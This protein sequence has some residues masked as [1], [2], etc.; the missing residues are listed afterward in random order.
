MDGVPPQGRTD[1]GNR[2]SAAINDVPEPSGNWPVPALLF[3]SSRRSSASTS[4]RHS[5]PLVS[6]RIENG[7][8]FGLDSTDNVL[9][10]FAFPEWDSVW[11]GHSHP[12]LPSWYFVLDDSQSPGSVKVVVLLVDRNHHS[13]VAGLDGNG[14]KRWEVPLSVQLSWNG[15]SLPS[16]FGP[17]LA[18][19]VQ[20]SGE[21]RFFTVAVNEPR[22]PSRL[23][24]LDPQ[25]GE[26]T[27]EYCHPG[28]FKSYSAHDFDND[29][30][31]E[32]VFGG[33][34]NPGSG[35]GHPCVVMFDLPGTNEPS[36]SRDFFGRPAI[37][38]K[39]YLLLPRSRLADA[40]RYMAIVYNLRLTN[41]SEIVAGVISG[42]PD[43]S[44]SDFY[45]LKPDFSLLRLLIGD[46]HLTLFQRLQTSAE[47]VSP[48]SFASDRAR[49]GTLLRFSKAPNGNDPGLENLFAN[50]PL[51]GSGQMPCRE[52]ALKH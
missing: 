41:Q 37:A 11:Y 23:V 31:D 2:F 47:S 28:W 1:K 34:N 13:Q 20:A 8:I 24:I 51:C 49:L 29:G 19:I 42:L 15:Q 9:W 36:G 40:F 6:C 16:T 45:T 33:V 25:T 52:F 50:A 27:G 21:L 48:A 10:R 32:L 46:S 4:G 26:I 14:K 30:S 17:A 18:G 44:F 7:V 38:V 39:N 5:R 43:G 35:F 22:F 3:S 12:S